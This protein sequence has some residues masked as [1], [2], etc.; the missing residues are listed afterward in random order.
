[1]QPQSEQNFWQPE[2]PSMPEAPGPAVQSEL[3]PASANMQPLSWQASE[4]IHHEKAGGW[5]AALFGLAAVLVAIDLFLIKSVTFSILIV[6]MA[7]AVAVIARRP[8]R[9][10]TYLLSPLGIRI[11]DRTFNLHEF[12]AF[13]IVQ[14]QAMYSIRLIPN[15]RFM[16]LVSVYFPPELGEQIVDMFGSSLPME[17]LKLDFLD[18]LT[19]KIRF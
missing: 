17:D 16:P 12:R 7:F 6:V 4:Y 18:Q 8:P 10:M 5:Y 2:Q 14:E 13:G 11:N 1:M 9:V 3:D 19:E 15:K